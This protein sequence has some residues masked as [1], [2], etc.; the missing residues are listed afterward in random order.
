MTRTELVN[1]IREKKSFLCVGLDTDLGRIPK[2]LLSF[3]DPIFEFNRQIIDATKS[4]CIAY[5]INT[6][7]YEALGGAGWEAMQKT[8]NYIPGTHFTIADAKRGDI[9]NTS[10]HYARAFFETLNFDAI[11]VS[12]YMGVDSIRPFL[13]YKGKWTIVLALTSNA[14]ANDFEMQPSGDALLYERVIEI[15]SQW[16]TPENMMFVIGATRP[17]T[18]KGIRVLAPAHFYLVPGVGAQGGELKQIAENA[19][20]PD[21]GLIVNVSR[22]IIYSSSSEDFAEKA[23]DVAAAYQQQM[24]VF[25]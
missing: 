9:G 7:F 20:L 13:E 11:T 10:A 24:Q 5:K 15:L 2:H 4:N 8:L 18:F 1:Q 25:F 3:P 12:P 22:S 14:G 19:I 6:A 21:I 17:E 16:G 23:G